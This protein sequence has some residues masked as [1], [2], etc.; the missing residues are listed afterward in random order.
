MSGWKQALPES[1]IG[2]V[3]PTIATA[4]GGPLAGLATAAIAKVFGFGDG[5]SQGQLAA[6]VGKASPDH[7]LALKNAEQDFIIRLHELDV[8]IERVN[9]AD[10]ASAR[11]RESTSGDLWTPRLLAALSVILFAGCVVFVFWLALAGVGTTDPLVMGLVGTM[12][13][14]ASAKT[15]LVYTYYF[16]SSAGSSNKDNLLYKSTPTER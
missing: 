16:G 1:V 11:L 13:G 6:A 14:Y 7:L 12:I 2:V 15:E 5:V 4:L 3:A 8:D 9:A 10:R